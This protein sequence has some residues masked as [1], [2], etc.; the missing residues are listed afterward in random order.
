MASPTS[1]SPMTL[2][3]PDYIWNNMAVCKLLCLVCRRQVS[4]AC[5]HSTLSYIPI[6]QLLQDMGDCLAW[7][8]HKKRAWIYDHPFTHLWPNPAFCVWTVMAGKK[9]LSL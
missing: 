2:H 5:T 1:S 6:L 3:M 4:M 7:L 8:S 9:T